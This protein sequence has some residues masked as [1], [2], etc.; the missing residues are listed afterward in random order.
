MRPPPSPPRRRPDVSSPERPPTVDDYV[1]ATLAVA[2]M[3]IV[4]VGSGVGIAVLLWT[5]PGWTLL[6]VTFLATCYRVAGWLIT[7]GR[8]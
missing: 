5:Q 3:I 7:S 2:L 6:G 8:L 1:F 4:I